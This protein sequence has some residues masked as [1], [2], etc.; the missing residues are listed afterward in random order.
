MRSN[1]S[2]TRRIDLSAGSLQGRLLRDVLDQRGRRVTV[3]VTSTS[4]EPML[5][6]GDRIVV[7]GVAPSELRYGDI[8]VFDSPLC[9]LVVHR[10]MWQVPPR[11]EPRA[12]FTKGDALAFCDRPI[13]VA[14]VVGRVVEVERGRKRRMMSPSRRCVGWIAAAVTWGWRR[15]L[16]RIAR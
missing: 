13:A 5:R 15:G 11:G 3:T 6:A 8:V 1:S 16:E 14:G 10:L 2:E 4:M 12:V 9:G 7:E